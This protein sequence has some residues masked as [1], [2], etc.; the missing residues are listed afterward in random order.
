MYNKLTYT[1]NP[2]KI[3]VKQIKKGLLLNLKKLK[4]KYELKVDKKAI[5]PICE[6]TNI[7]SILLI[8]NILEV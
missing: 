7:N 5:N 1:I 6:K 8:F 2:N 4:I 3:E